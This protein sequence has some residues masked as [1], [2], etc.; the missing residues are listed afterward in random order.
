MFCNKKRKNVLYFGLDP[1]HFFSKDEVFHFP[2]IETIPLSYERVKPFLLTSYSHVLFTSRT[3]ITYYFHYN[4]SKEKNFI[5]IGLGTVAQLMKF[6]LSPAYIPETACSES[7]VTLLEKIA[8]AHV[9]YPHSARSRPLLPEY[10][11]QHRGIPFVLYDTYSK[12]VRLPNLEMFHELI[13]T[14]PST[15]E[16]FGKICDDLPDRKKCRAIGPITENALNKLF[17]STNLIQ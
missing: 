9:L 6:G 3:A 14:S 13:F 2:L 11:T 5:C 15:V 1:S 7:V 4:G 8:Y 17:H 16:A 10:L 12:N